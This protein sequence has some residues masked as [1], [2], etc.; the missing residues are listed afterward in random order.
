[1]QNAAMVK[2]MWCSHKF[3]T[4]RHHCGDNNHKIF[5][6][7]TFVFFHLF[8]CNRGGTIFSRSH[9]NIVFRIACT[10]YMWM[11]LRKWM[12]RFGSV[13]STHAEN[14][15]RNLPPLFL[16]LP[17]RL[18]LYFSSFLPSSSFY[19][20]F[21]FHWPWPWL[22]SHSTRFRSICDMLMHVPVMLCYSVIS[23]INCRS[24]SFSE[25]FCCTIVFGFFFDPSPSHTLVLFPLS[26]WKLWIV[27]AG[28]LIS[29]PCHWSIHFALL[30]KKQKTHR[31]RQTEI[32]RLRERN[33]SLP[34][35]FF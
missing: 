35:I 24:H 32:K 11:C 14:S 30:Q 9:T 13:F 5:I 26:A 21:L 6:N 31:Q 1:M 33:G 7:S 16:L 34:Y 22:I 20:V 17:L 18:R 15:K 8:V 23:F 25:N 2:R 19:F 29:F 27:C 10:A 4:H 3:V 12:C 28:K